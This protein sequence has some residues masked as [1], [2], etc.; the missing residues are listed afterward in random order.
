MPLRRIHAGA[1]ALLL[2]A[3]A[4]ARKPG[5]IDIAPKKAKIYGI[6]RS[7]RLTARILDKKGRALESGTPDWTSSNPAVAQVEAGRVVAK[8]AGKTTITATFEDVSAQVPVEVVDVQ[9]IDIAPPTL[10]LVGPA[11][12]S[13]PLAY[14][15][16]DSKQNAV[17]DIVPSWSSTN[18]KAA[19]VSS[20]GVV[21][22]VAKGNA[23]IVAR[24]GDVQGASEVVVDV[25]PIARVELRPATALGRVHESQRF[26]V[27][28]YGPDGIPIP[29]V[30][31]LYT[32]S[33]P[34][35]ATVDS[36]GVAACH[37]AGAATIRVELA[38]AKA[39]ATLLVN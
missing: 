1:L 29:E 11:G 16:R 32:S 6:E 14:T 31:A 5:S 21:T 17:R 36:S 30:A 27:T 23:N 34:S 2:V 24:I 25:R 38:G 4:C 22:S 33:D 39:E 35:V 26:Q 28:A 37:K 10:S 7:Q 15:V 12:T 19:T 20:Q 3:T 18:E 13:V 9:G 8:K